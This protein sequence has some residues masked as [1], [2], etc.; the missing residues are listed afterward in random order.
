MTVTS[1]VNEIVK[2]KEKGQG[3][4]KTLK[5]IPQKGTNDGEDSGKFP[6]YTV[7]ICTYSI[8]L[9]KNISLLY[10]NHQILRSGVYF[11]KIRV[12]IT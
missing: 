9:L 2:S 6:N 10:V 12:I 8:L 5:V 11:T 4:T 1:K 7:K 3:P